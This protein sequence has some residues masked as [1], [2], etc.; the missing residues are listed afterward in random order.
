MPIRARSSLPGPVTARE[1]IGDLPAI[2][3]DQ[4]RRG[5][6]RFSELSRYAAGAEYSDYV[7][8]NA[9][10]AGLRGR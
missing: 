3:G 5:A 10:L 7:D 6:R 2:R 9:M 4:V 8:R 1:A